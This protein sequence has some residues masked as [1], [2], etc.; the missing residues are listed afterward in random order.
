MKV[1]FTGLYPMWHYH[2]V[3]ELNYLQ[4]CLNQGDEVTL[5]HCDADQSC[6]EANQNKNLAHCLRC[7]GIYQHGYQLLDGKVDQKT[8]IHQNYR[9]ASPEWLHAALQDIESLKSIKID[10]FD[11]GYAVYSSLVD[12]T[13]EKSP[14]LGLY[15]DVTQRLIL[16][17]YRIHLSAKHYLSA[18][19]YD[20][21]YV[22]NGRYAGARPWIR[23]CEAAKVPFYTHE[24]TTS[25][26]HG[27]R[28]ENTLPHYP[29]P[30]PSMVQ[31]T[32]VKFR[33][34][35]EAIEEGHHF[36][37]ERPGGVITG[38]NESF[39]K[40]QKQGKLPG[41]WNPDLKNI[42]FFTSSDSEFWGIQDMWSG[43]QGIEQKEAVLKLAT[44][45]AVLRKDIHFYLRVHPNSRSEVNR[46]WESP[47]IL[48][49][50][51]LTLI[52]PE[53]DI[54][55]YDLLWNVAA[56]VT[57]FS[58]IGIEATYWGKPSM[59]LQKAN[60]WGIDAVYEP[61]DLDAAVRLLCSDLQPKPQINAVKY[62]VNIRRGGDRLP[63]SKPVNNYTITFKG[64]ILEARQ[65]VHEWLGETE[66]RKEVTG[67][68]KWLQDR[69]DKMRFD[70]I[71]KEYDGNLAAISVK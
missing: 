7:M 58:T 63:Y 61:K 27:I 43:S 20:R 56:C 2:Y 13:K 44:E 57:Y 59:I 16:D 55:S 69:K 47:E 23:A 5:L 10:D 48:A 8:L 9:D 24:R 22:F 53:S 35:P 18:E 19:T 65:E 1:L 4:E 51:N 21:V 64:A 37:Q 67:W 15:R 40:D 6:C 33:D 11:L 49:L 42:V 60:Y 52:Q 70:Q 38:W 14:D 32:W 68:R 25:L 50:E 12:R 26:C 62:G 29:D 36:Y 45:T 71:I 30:Y 39:V 46:W 17:A 66:K 54:S 31:A 34:D 41:D 28:F 3:A